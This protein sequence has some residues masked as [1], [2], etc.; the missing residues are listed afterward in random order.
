[1][2][3]SGAREIQ[4]FISNF[5]FGAPKKGER[6]GEKE[7][8]LFE[9]RSL[10]FNTLFPEEEEGE[11]KKFGSAKNNAGKCGGKDSE[12]QIGK[13]GETSIS[14]IW[15]K[16]CATQ[17]ILIPREKEKKREKRNLF[18]LKRALKRGHKLQINR[19][20]GDQVSNFA[21]DSVFRIGD[22]ISA[23]KTL[24]I[25][26][27]IIL[28]NMDSN[29]VPS[30]ALFSNAPSE[31][32]P[33]YSG[34][35]NVVRNV[36]T[37]G[38]RIAVNDSFLAGDELGDEHAIYYSRPATIFAAVCAIIFTVV[39]I[40]GN[41]LT[42]VALLRCPKLR[43]HATTMFVISLALSD[44]LF[45]AVNLPLTASRYIHEEWRLGAVLCR[46][47]PFFFYGNVAASLM[48]MVAITINRYVLISCHGNY[49]RIYSRT[50][51]FLMIVFVWLFSFGMLVPPWR[52]FGELSA[53]R[54]QLSH[55]PSLRKM[56]VPPRSS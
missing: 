49:G 2:E 19:P 30:A 8:E 29:T 56:E 12:S 22:R 32:N 20:A 37:D 33:A 48:N 51:I 6:E 34:V 35:Q 14:K 44:L 21:S 11:D 9:S 47:F 18:S 46:L 36:A 45:A 26:K 23:P 28:K 3:N 4:S 25:D 10:N 15:K 17:T 43:S 16:K 54:K 41:L 40:A 1:M 50:N 7:F 24:K 39:G 27:K 38:V 55:A 13:R 5:I 52:K 53:S 42:V 31:S